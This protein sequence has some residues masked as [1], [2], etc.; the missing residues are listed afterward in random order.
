MIRCAKCK[1][2]CRSQSYAGGLCRKCDRKAVR[3]ANEQFARAAVQDQHRVE[4]RRRE[5]ESLRW[6]GRVARGTVWGSHDGLRSVGQLIAA[7]WRYIASD[8]GE[9]PEIGE[10]TW[11]GWPWFGVWFTFTISAVLTAYLLWGEV[12][13]AITFLL[14]G[15]VLGA[16]HGGVRAARNE[17][18]WWLR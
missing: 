16:I 17:W 6:P 8:R 10:P 9:H 13:A 14:S 3:A 4:A 2:P 7:L 5:L 15:P 12:L 18:D 11:P 1:R